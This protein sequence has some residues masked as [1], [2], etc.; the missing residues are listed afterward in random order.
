MVMK[1]ST[2]V[3]TIRDLV[4]GYR[5]SGQDGVVALGGKLNVRPAYQRAF[6]Y[7]PADRDRVMMSV[8][9]GLPL[10][11]M[12]WAKNPDGS[13]EVIDGQQRIIS[14]CQYLTNNDGNG[15]PI[16]INFNK[17]LNQLFMGLSPEKQNEILNYRLQVYVCTGTDDEKLEWFHTINIAGKQ[18]TDQEL[19]NANYT[20]P[21]LSDAKAQFSKK[22]NNPAINLAFYDN[23]E[24]KTLLS[25]SGVDANRQALLELILRWITNSLTAD[26]D[27]EKH[28]WPAVAEYMATHRD[29]ESAND[30]WQYYE[31]VI[32]WVKNTF[33]HYR[34]DMRGIEW[35]LLY[36]KYGHNTYDP[37]ALDT[38]LN[39]LYEIYAIDPDGLKKSGFYEYVLS[40]NRSQIWHRAFSQ[41]QQQQAYQ[42]QNKKC[43]GRCGRALPFETL[44]AHH[45]IA[46]ADGGE[47]TIENCLMLCHDCH[48]DITATQNQK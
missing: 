1:I 45:K 37:N 8:Y 44:E 48:A 29:C 11:S 38:E 3:I 33:P 9:N 46:F 5:D 2:P 31:T 15:N 35:G 12:Y 28:C 21:W 7:E 42:N 43:G 36:N 6:V 18:M 14:I 40:G 30:L 41:K 26:Y 39:H 27:N 4:N 10:N 24:R 25:Q 34:K 22:S 17:K 20:G 23:D 32:K 19:L 47:T 16:A 13:F